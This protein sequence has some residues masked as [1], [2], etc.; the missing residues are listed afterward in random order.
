MPSPLAAR[1][2]M[3]KSRLHRANQ[4]F[5]VDSMVCDHST[6][7][8]AWHHRLQPVKCTECTLPIY[9]DMRKPLRSTTVH[10]ASKKQ[11]A[12]KILGRVR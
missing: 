4:N 1:S 2:G 9:G 8:L 12:S 5:E 7:G 11:M 6:Q 3:T 10:V